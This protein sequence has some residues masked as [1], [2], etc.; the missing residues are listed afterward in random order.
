MQQRTDGDP[1][2]LSK[3][4]CCNSFWEVFFLALKGCLTTSSRLA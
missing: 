3:A 2:N 4:C 1:V